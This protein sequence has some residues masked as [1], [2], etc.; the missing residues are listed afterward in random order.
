MSNEYTVFKVGIDD[1]LILRYE[2]LTTDSIATDVHFPNGHWYLE[3][4]LW[5]PAELAYYATYRK[6]KD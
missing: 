2:D 6:Y 4:V 3:K 1:K 5:K